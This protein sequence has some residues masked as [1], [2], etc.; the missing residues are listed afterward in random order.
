MKIIAA[1]LLLFFSA[2]ASAVE[3]TN[4]AG[5]RVVINFSAG[6]KGP[7]GV[8]AALVASR[9]GKE[10]VLR[11]DTNIDFIGAECRK[12]PQGRPL[13]VFQAYC[14]GSGCKDLDNYGIIDPADLR[15]LLVPSD[16]NRADA[17]RIFDEA[18]MPMNDVF[19]AESRQLIREIHQR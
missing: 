9:D 19:S 10:T 16:W 15:V 12:T 11:Y 17:A 8:E 18:V 4:C 14:G 3:V 2:L 7:E 1:L 6:S 13:I 5:A